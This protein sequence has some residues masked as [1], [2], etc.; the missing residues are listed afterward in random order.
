MTRRWIRV[1]VPTELNP[2]TVWE[3]TP[4][5]PWRSEYPR[6]IRPVRDECRVEWRLVEVGRKSPSDHKAERA[7]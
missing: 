6:F 5:N 2:A 4:L 3:H 7:R 1:P